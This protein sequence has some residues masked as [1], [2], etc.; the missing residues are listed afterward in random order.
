MMV[1]QKYLYGIYC[2][3]SIAASSTC[4]WELEKNFP[5]PAIH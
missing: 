4:V 2:Y 5:Q 3:I 1:M